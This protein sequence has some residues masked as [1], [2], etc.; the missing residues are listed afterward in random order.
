MMSPFVQSSCC[1]GFGMN[2]THC[3]TTTVYFK[4]V[5]RELKISKE[6]LVFMEVAK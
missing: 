1:D 4:M 3:G 5:F 2:V 6:L